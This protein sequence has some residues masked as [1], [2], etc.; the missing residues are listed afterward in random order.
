MQGVKTAKFFE[1]R[2]RRI[3][4]FGGVLWHA[5][6]KRMLIALPYHLDLSFEQ[7]QTAGFLWS[8]NSAGLR[9][10]SSTQPGTPSGIYTIRDKEY[11]IEK[12]PK[13]YRRDVRIGLERCE[14]REVDGDTLLRE[15]L[16]MNIETMQRQKRWEAEYGD[17]KQ[18]ERLVRAIAD[19]DGIFALGAFVEGRLGA[20]AVCAREDGWLHHLHQFSALELLPHYCNHAL[21][22]E[23]TRREMA[24]PDVE[25]FCDG[26]TPLVPLDGLDHFK[27]N[28]LFQLEARNTVSHLH[29]VLDHT[30]A[31]S[32]GKA[33]LGRWQAKHPEDQRI[34]RVLSIVEAARAAKQPMTVEEFGAQ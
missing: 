9:Y 30:L 33:L 22:F 21:C 10:G 23:M 24:R 26:F 17:A 34:S 3:E 29:P 16:Q 13:K 4:E 31:S 8:T 25:A 20:Y 6:E 27:K 5:V 14:I 7:A 12:L 28:Q 15:G 11:S 1:R 18:F 32:A 2:G 19:S